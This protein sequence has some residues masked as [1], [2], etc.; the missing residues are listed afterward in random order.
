MRLCQF[1][2]FYDRQERQRS[3]NFQEL[4]GLQ[5]QDGQESL[6]LSQWRESRNC[7]HILSLKISRRWYLVWAVPE[8]WSIAAVWGDKL[9]SSIKFHDLDMLAG[10]AIH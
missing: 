9:D 10:G 2:T 8:D 7:L 4:G 5:Y 1:A 6:L 3:E